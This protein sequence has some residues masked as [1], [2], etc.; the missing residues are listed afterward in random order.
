MFGTD[1]LPINLR[2]HRLIRYGHMSAVLLVISVALTLDILTLNQQ[3]ALTQV[4]MHNRIATAIAGTCGSLSGG[5]ANLH[6]L[7]RQ[8]VSLDRG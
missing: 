8:L 7:R 3:L 6:C 1:T 5:D 4:G 2:H